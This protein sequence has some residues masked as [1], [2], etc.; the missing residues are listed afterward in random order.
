MPHENLPLSQKNIG[1]AAPKDACLHSKQMAT[2]Q[3]QISTSPSFPSLFSLFLLSLPLSLPFRA[4][5]PLPLAPAPIPLPPPRPHTP[6]PSHTLPLSLPH[7]PLSPPPPLLLPIASSNRPTPP[8]FPA[9]PLFPLNL[10][11]VSP[12]S[13]LS[14]PPLPILSSVCPST[15][16]LCPHSPASLGT[17]LTL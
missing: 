12:S 14:Y 5:P 16:D 13:F 8:S 1:P 10:S 11:L 6:S 17:L 2:N 15:L 7:P 3:W 4:H 9:P